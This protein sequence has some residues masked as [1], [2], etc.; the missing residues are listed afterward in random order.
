[1]QWRDGDATRLDRMEQ[2]IRTTAKE[3]A[4]DMNLYVTFGPVLGIEPTAMN[5]SLQA[6]L[7]SAAEIECPK[8]WR[9]I[10]SGALHDAANLSALMPTAMVFVPSINGI[11]HDFAED[12]DETELVMGLRVLARAVGHL[13]NE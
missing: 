4:D 7:S 8:M 5:S 10:T 2:I 3:V 1:M 12:T 11:S 9:K 6:I 13:R